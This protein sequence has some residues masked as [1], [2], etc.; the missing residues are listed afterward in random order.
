MLNSRW[1]F[2]SSHRLSV[3]SLFFFLILI[4]DDILPKEICGYIYQFDPT[5]REIFSMDVVPYLSTKTL[6]RCQLK[7]SNTG[8]DIFIVLDETHAIATNSLTNPTYRS[9]IFFHSPMER[10][11]YRDLF[12]CKEI[13]KTY[14]TTIKFVDEEMTWAEF[15]GE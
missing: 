12:E 5:Y 3:D 10:H 6:Y 1:I 9:T 7:S 8:N 13:I 14:P 15:C 2:L 4:M 11:Q